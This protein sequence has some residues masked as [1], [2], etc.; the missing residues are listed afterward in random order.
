MFSSPWGASTGLQARFTLLFF[1]ITRNFLIT[2]W[3]RKQHPWGLQC[4]RTDALKHLWGLQLIL[5]ACYW[6]GFCSLNKIVSNL[7]V[8][9]EDVM[10]AE[11]TATSLP[12][13][14]RC[15]KKVRLNSTYF[16]E[17]FLTCDEHTPRPVLKIS[18]I[19]Q[20]LVPSELAKIFIY[21]SF[22]SIV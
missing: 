20:V 11:F 15:T 7:K 13:S 8:G 19:N 3:Q 6:F 10:R 9:A 5:R 17:C 14:F 1:F 22:I 21:I 2:P 12:W 18:T 16:L 4:R